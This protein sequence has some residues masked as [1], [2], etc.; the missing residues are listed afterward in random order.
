METSGLNQLTFWQVIY[1]IFEG[2][3]QPF[4]VFQGGSISW[5]QII[6]WTSFI[7]LFLWFCIKVVGGDA[8]PPD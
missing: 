7:N 2:L 3:K 5:W 6:M 8:T 1:A 4:S